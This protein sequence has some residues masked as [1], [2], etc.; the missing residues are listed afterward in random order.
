M[1]YRNSQLTQLLRRTLGCLLAGC[2]S[3]FICEAENTLSYL[4]I[5]RDAAV[6]SVI[7]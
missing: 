5:S 2:R 7:C 4:L 6:M 1:A 3:C